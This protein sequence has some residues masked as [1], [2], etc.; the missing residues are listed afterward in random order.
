MFN[1]IY[2]LAKM[3]EISRIAPMPLARSMKQRR[4]TVKGNSLIISL[5]S[6]LDSLWLTWTS[7]RTKWPV[8]QKHLPNNPIFFF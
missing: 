3:L 2:F 8:E 7:S 4:M 5:R 6:A 1:I